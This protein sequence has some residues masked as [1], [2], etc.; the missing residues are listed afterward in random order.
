MLGEILPET[1]L[2]TGA[3]RAA[4]QT[5]EDNHISDQT[6]KDSDIVD[7][8][9]VTFISASINLTFAR[10]SRMNKKRKTQFFIQVYSCEMNLL[11]QCMIQWQ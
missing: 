8:H 11:T 1:E 9:H 3:S 6:I 5:M 7:H 10:K 4:E 2:I